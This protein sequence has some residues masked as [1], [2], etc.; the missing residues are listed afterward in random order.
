MSRCAEWIVGISF[1]A[2]LAAAPQLSTRGHYFLRDGQ[3]FFWIG[4]T[5]WTLDRK[6]VV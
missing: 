4:D 3:P 6:S 5:N 2:A 1:A